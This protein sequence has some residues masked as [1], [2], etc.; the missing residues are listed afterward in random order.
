MNPKRNWA[1]AFAAEAAAEP[2]GL[3]QGPGARSV[4]SGVPGAA[5]DVEAGMGEPWGS[6]HPF[7]HDPIRAL[8]AT[9]GQA[10]QLPTQ[11][12]S[13]SQTLQSLLSPEVLSYLQL[14]QQQQAP[15]PALLSSPLSSLPPAVI[16]QLLA[17]MQGGGGGGP[18]ADT[19]GFRLGQ[20]DI[21][22]GGQEASR[23]AA[24]LHQQQQQHEASRFASALQQQQQHDASRFASALQQQQQQ[25]ASAPSFSSPLPQPGYRPHQVSAWRGLRPTGL[26]SGASAAVYS[27]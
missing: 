24:A 27:W 20:W 7:N 16:Q 15:Q 10:A 14:Q 19:P 2:L 13:A 1:S 17:G 9:P 6:S 18:H 3:A 26:P 23:L 22:E 4:A 11:P 25:Q 12:Q 5:A 8:S 21:Q